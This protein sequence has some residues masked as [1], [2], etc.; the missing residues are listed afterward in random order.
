[1]AEEVAC[2]LRVLDE[3][4]EGRCVSEEEREEDEEEEDGEGAAS[5]VGSSHEVGGVPPGLKQIAQQQR[6]R[7]R[8]NRV[9]ICVA[10]CRSSLYVVQQAVGRLQW[11]MVVR[12]TPEVSVAWLE[13]T[14]ST[15]MI[16]PSQ[17]MSKVE[18]ILNVCRKANLAA[19]LQAMQAMYP[20]DFDFVPQTWILSSSAPEQAADLEQVMSEKKGWTYIC[21]PTAG[22]QGRGLRLV[23]TFA[24]LR[25]P[26]RDAFPTS[27]SRSAEYV[28]Q[29]Y[30]SRPLLIDGFK[31]DCRCYVIV[32]SVVP[33][34]AYLFEEGL[35]RFCT[36]KYERP[37]GR[38]LGNACMHLTNY[39][40]NKRS[41]AFDSARAHD[42]GSKRALSSAFEGLEA[43]GGPGAEELWAAVQALAEKTLLA[44]R[45]ALVERMAG[46]NHGA[47]HP[48]GPK[49]FHILGFDVMFDENHRPLLLELNAN[50]S[51]SVLQPAEDPS[52]SGCKTEVSE[53]DLAVKAELISQALLCANPPPHGACLRKRLA[54]LDALGSFSKVHGASPPVDEPLPLDDDGELVSGVT[55]TTAAPR[56]DRPGRCPALRP[57]DFDAHPAAMSYVRT[58]LRAYRVWRHYAFQPPGSLPLRHQSQRRYLGFGRHQFRALCEAAGLV[59]PGGSPGAAE[60][61][62]CWPDR[63]TAELFVTRVLRGVSAEEAQGSGA[64]LD[65]PSFLRRL[66]GPVGEILVGGAS[67][68]PS[69][70][71]AFVARAFPVVARACA[72]DAA[73]GDQS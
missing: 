14:D 53:L 59:G 46:G 29:R 6:K 37:R 38:N 54:W 58:H 12:D 55:A 30:V 32:T 3:M 15:A 4:H 66:V 47:F 31:F 19:C 26:L 35:A 23:K 57:L 65:F 36:A 48:V 42:A 24:E 16:C 2:T 25:V 69:P 13:H 22:S 71:E 7:R 27:L 52:V 60:D 68:G 67:S 62:P 51:M 41:G 34:R 73:L 20:E 9:S 33:L 17:V 10:K 5:D 49:G 18:G 63:A 43:Q 21:K 8:A 45:P 72:D 1:M 70:M 39:A 44:L 64:A 61:G 50:S 40:V 11:E 28:V 56:P